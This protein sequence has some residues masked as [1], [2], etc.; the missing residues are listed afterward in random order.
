MKKI[1]SPGVEI[2]PFYGIAYYDYARNEKVCYPIF[3]NL[4]VLLWRD[5]VYWI[6]NPKG[7]K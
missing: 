4:I 7:R 2:P 6:K 5:F 1:I 3:I